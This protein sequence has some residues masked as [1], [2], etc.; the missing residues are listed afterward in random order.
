M[1]SIVMTGDLSLL[2]PVAASIIGDHP[3]VG[4]CPP[5]S[6][7]GWV[8]A[9]ASIGVMAGTILLAIKT[10]GMSRTA[11]QQLDH[12]EAR[13]AYERQPRLFLKDI[14]VAKAPTVEPGKR[15]KLPF[16]SKGM[17]NM[18][19]HPIVIT[20]IRVLGQD[21][22]IIATAH[23]MMP[24]RPGDA[25]T[26]DEGSRSRVMGQMTATSSGTV[27]PEAVVRDAANLHI[28][29]RHGADTS[30]PWILIAPRVSRNT[31]WMSFDG[32]SGRLTQA[33]QPTNT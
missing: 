11:Q 23:P 5:S 30:V 26:P 7:L 31:G 33:G 19:G 27:A 10:A 12:L 21:G 15:L 2:T 4:L 22:T 17:A 20:T 29:F 8:S 32:S 1:G 18:G 24:I 25:V 14:W 3:V 6:A 9:L 16:S 13:E 28:E